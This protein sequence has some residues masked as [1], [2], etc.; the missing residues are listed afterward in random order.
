MERSTTRYVLDFDA[1]PAV[2]DADLAR[3]I[4]GKGASLAVMANRLG[5][6]VPP[7]FTITTDACREYLGGR[8]PKGWT[9]SSARTWPASSAGSA[10]AS[11]RL[12]IRFW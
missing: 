7:G 4:G 11:A 5:L 2:S 6:P 12:A 10:G 1:P 9:M 8:W 3:L